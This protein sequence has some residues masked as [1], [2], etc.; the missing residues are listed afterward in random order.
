MQHDGLAGEPLEIAGRKLVL[1]VDF[2]A[3]SPSSVRQ[4]CVAMDSWAEA[5]AQ[6]QLR[7]D[8][9]VAVEDIAA[10]RAAD[11][12]MYRHFLD[13]LR[14]LVEG[15]VDVHPHNHG[16]FDPSSGRPATAKS[17]RRHVVPGYT[18]RASF[19]YDTVYRHEWDLQAWLD[20]VRTEHARLLA[21]LGVQA[22]RHVAF[23]AGGWDHG[24]SAADTRAYVEAVAGARFTY[25][26][27]ASYG[28]YGTESWRVGKPYGENV[29]RLTPDLIEVAA[30]WSVNCGVHPLSPRSIVSL[31]RLL[32]QPGVATGR[33]G[34]AVAAL[35]F[36]H[37]FTRSGAAPRR[38]TAIISWLNRV[39]TLLGM[40]SV[41]VA[42][43]LS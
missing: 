30:T 17:D 39:R 33:D 36:D 12:S 24:A 19:Y 37:L 2:E 32:R 8:F 34:A 18:K 9:F 20:V 43:L 31:A 3:F 6:R 25:D 29:F 15:G 26:S 40:T 38:A 42:E 1:T 14:R 28:T 27:S 22:P 23:R 5:S 21:D 35:H 7:F 10:L 16:P 4:W 11:S 41:H 13:S